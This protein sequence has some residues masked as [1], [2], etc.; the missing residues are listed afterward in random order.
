M[1][2][3]RQPGAA[4]LTE[5]DYVALEAAGIDRATADLAMLRRVDAQQGRDIIGQNGNRDCSGLLFPYYWPRRAIS[6]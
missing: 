5:Q 3:F 6:L 1:I 4:P 2:E